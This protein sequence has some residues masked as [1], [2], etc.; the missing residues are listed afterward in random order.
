MFSARHKNAVNDQ[1]HNKR[2]I[3]VFFSF[4]LCVCVCCKGNTDTLQVCLCHSQATLRPIEKSWK[5]NTGVLKLERC[6]GQP[7]TPLTLM[8]QR[9]FP[10]LSFLKHYPKRTCQMFHLSPPQNNLELIALFG[11][12]QAERS[13]FHPFSDIATSKS[14]T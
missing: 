3:S 7:Q 1:L 10:A 14:V 4:L 11:K 2:F 13:F 12:S 8:W 9:L 6:H 5:V